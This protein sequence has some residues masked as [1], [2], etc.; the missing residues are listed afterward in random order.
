MPSCSSLPQIPLHS[1]R[2]C[3]IARSAMWLSRVAAWLRER[4]CDAPRGVARFRVPIS[5]VLRA[6]RAAQRDSGRR[7]APHHAAIG[8]R[9]AIPGAGAR[10]ATPAARFRARVCATLSGNRAAQRDSGRGFAP[11]DNCMARHDSGCGSAPRRAAQ[12]LHNACD[13]YICLCI[14]V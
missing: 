2:L 3:V 4:V 13:S 10:R 14:S 1:A 8:R 9:G 6:Y 11:R 5:A 12:L 7:C